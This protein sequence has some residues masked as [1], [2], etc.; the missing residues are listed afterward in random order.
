MGRGRSICSKSNENGSV[1]W[2]MAIAS[3][4]VLLKCGFHCGLNLLHSFNKGCKV[5]SALLIEQR[6]PQ[7]CACGITDGG[8]VGQSTVRYESK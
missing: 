1:L 8:N 7:S 6:D 5:H 4:E 2:G 3:D